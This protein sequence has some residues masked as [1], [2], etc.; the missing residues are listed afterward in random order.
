M[1][2][3]DSGHRLLLPMYESEGRMRS[4]S[5]RCSI[6]RFPTDQSNGVRKSL[7]PK[8]F[9][10]RRLCFANA[11][12]L[13][14]LGSQQ[15]GGEGVPA[16]RGLIVEGGPDFLTWVQRLHKVGHNGYVIMGVYNGSWWEGYTCCFT[17]LPEVVIRTQGDEKGKDY[18]DA[19]ERALV[20]AGIEV[21][22]SNAGSAS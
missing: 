15:A 7:H 1:N 11:N 17:E 8:G 2:W 18:G 3:V 20:N 12:M 9:G 14:L 16:D 5:A 19:I 22:R 21:L 13:K 6:S 4:F 10:V